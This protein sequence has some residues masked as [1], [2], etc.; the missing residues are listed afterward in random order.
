MR[1]VVMTTTAV[2]IDLPGGHLLRQDGNAHYTLYRDGVP[3]GYI[4][5]VEGIYV[6][7]RGRRRDHA[8][9]IG[10]TVSLKHAIS[11]AMHAGAHS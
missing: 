9:E 10:Q 1:G 6:V 4:T 7:H 2:P 3:V 11:L 5:S 8:V